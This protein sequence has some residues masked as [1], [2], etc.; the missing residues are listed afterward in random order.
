MRTKRYIACWLLVVYL[1]TA[2]GPAYASLT[3]RC[4]AMKA[5]TEA[6]CCCHHG[7]AHC[8][9]S[10]STAPAQSAW[11]A[12]CC[13][14]RHSTEIEL[15]TNGAD[16]RTDKTVQPVSSALLSDGLS[17]AAPA[18]AFSER[19]TDRRAQFLCHGSV[20]CAGLRAPPARI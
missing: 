4:T 5:R 2:I 9:V 10:D 14:D 17:V 11:E 12:P 20:R 3:C 8:H 18:P 6:V 7:H 13:N 19:V 1:L 16:D 15:Y